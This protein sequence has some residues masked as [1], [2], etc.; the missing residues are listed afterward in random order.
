MA[1]PIGLITRIVKPV[2]GLVIS[3]DP[4]G[5]DST[6]AKNWRPYTAAIFVLLLVLSIFTDISLSDSELT[7]IGAVLVVMVGGRSYEKKIKKAL[8]AIGEID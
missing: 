4:T 7:A 5:Q 8:E 6:L 2:L 1:F 3:K